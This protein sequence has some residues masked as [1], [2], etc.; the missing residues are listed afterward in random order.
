MSA[1][2]RTVKGWSIN[3]KW[4]VWSGNISATQSLGPGPVG[5][6]EGPCR[7]CASG[8][9]GRW[10]SSAFAWP[11]SRDNQAHGDI[12]NVKILSGVILAPSG[13]SACSHVSNAGPCF[14]R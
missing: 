12:W 1:L 9:A 4:S 5:P 10:S 11:T 3:G 7:D 6:P 14:G 13:F 8:W 2:R